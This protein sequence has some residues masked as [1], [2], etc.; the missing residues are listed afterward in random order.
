MIRFYTLSWSSQR[1][2]KQFVYPLI[3]VRFS[4]PL[5]PHCGPFSSLWTLNCACDCTLFFTCP[6]LFNAFFGLQVYLTE[7]THWWLICIKTWHRCRRFK[8]AHELKITDYQILTLVDLFSYITMWNGALLISSAGKLR[9]SLPPCMR[10]LVAASEWDSAPLR[11]SD[12][13]STT[14]HV[15]LRNIVSPLNVEPV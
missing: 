2:S 7:P 8:S 3:N 12:T 9:P 15:W 14:K 10:S 5:K 6:P 1:T 13:F 11:A 4:A